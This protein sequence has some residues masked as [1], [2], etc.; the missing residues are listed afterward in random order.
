MQVQEE[1]QRFVPQRDTVL[2]VGVF[3]GVH[4]GHQRLIDYLKRQ[5]LPGDHLAGVVTFRGHP[6]VVLS[7][8]TTLHFLT[9]LDER[10]SLLNNLGIELVVPLTFDREMANLTAHQ[11]LGL[12]QVHLRM[13]GLVIGPDFALGRRRE[14]DVNVLHRIGKESGFW[15]EVVS[16]GMANGEVISSTAIRRA[17]SGGDIAKAN[18]LLG[19]RFTLTGRVT[20]GDERGKQ[21]GYPTANLEVDSEQA[22][23]GDGVYATVTHLGLQVY[24]SVTNIG[25]RPTFGKGERTVEVYLIG[26]D[27]VVY[28][29]EIKVEVV[30]K[31]RSEKH[32]PTREALIEQIGRDVQAAVSILEKVEHDRS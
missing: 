9:S 10:I 19:R 14:G 31:L 1:L 16:P 5:A 29:E 2:T 4:L 15:V 3:D 11:F 28:G 20:H 7:P 12:L 32:F 17:L 21:L 26:F 8:G 27:G 22:I 30:D 6:R 23:P 24:P 25:R 18:R 13:R